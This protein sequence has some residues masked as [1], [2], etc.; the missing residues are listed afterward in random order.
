LDSDPATTV[1][2]VA[3]ASTGSTLVSSKIALERAWALAPIGLSS[4]S[5]SVPDA[6][7]V[8]VAYRVGSLRRVA[9]AEVL[10]AIDESTKT[11]KLMSAA[12]EAVDVAEP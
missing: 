6:L 7:T 5:E 12:V 2:T 3:D 9:V 4:D 8:P 1:E 10:A 11:T